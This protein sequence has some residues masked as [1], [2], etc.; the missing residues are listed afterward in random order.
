LALLPPEAAFLP[1]GSPVAF[2]PLSE[3]GL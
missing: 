2:Y 3:I 1:E